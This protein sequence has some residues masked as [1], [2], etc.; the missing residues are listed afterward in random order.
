MQSKTGARS[1][2]NVQSELGTAEGLRDALLRPRGSG[3]AF[4]TEAVFVGVGCDVQQIVE[5][6][7]VLPLDGRIDDFLDEVVAGDERRG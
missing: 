4:E 1:V 3:V 7:V 2:V 5:W 6:F